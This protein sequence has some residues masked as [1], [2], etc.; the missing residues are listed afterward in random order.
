MRT[1]RYK[2][3]RNVC[4]KLDFPFAMDLYA[5]RSLE[6]MRNSG[7]DGKPAMVGK[8]TLK[9]YIWR[10]AEELYDP[11]Q[12]PDELHNLA[13]EPGHQTRAHCCRCARRSR[14]GRPR[15]RICGCGGMAWQ[16]SGLGSSTMRG[17][18]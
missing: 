17:R 1:R 15:Q 6:G 16:C 18:V 8:R 13:A 3:H 2:Y 11:E 5:S 14:G 7:S 12:D 9:S 10:P 4:W